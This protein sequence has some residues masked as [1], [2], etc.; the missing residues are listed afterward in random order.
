MVDLDGGVCLRLLGLV[1]F[2]NFVVIVVIVVLLVVLL[3]CVMCD[4]LCC[5]M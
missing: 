5:E 1:W 3:C 4:V 2:W